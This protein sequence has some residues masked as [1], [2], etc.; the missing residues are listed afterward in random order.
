MLPPVPKEEQFELK[1]LPIE[2]LVDESAAVLHEDGPEG[3]THWFCVK[4][5]LLPEDGGDKYAVFVKRLGDRAPNAR[6][7]YRV[8]LVPEAE[9][10]SE[11]QPSV[12]GDSFLMDIQDATAK[13]ESSPYVRDPSMAAFVE[14]HADEDD[15]CHKQ[16]GVYVRFSELQAFVHERMTKFTG[17]SDLGP[18]G[19]AKEKDVLETHIEQWNQEWA[20][21]ARAGGNTNGCKTRKECSGFHVTYFKMPG[22]LQAKVEDRLRQNWDDFYE[23]YGAGIAGTT[24]A[25]FVAGNRGYRFPDFGGE[26]LQLLFPI[27][28]ELRE[29]EEALADT[30]RRRADVREKFG[31]RPDVDFQHRLWRYGPNFSVKG[32]L[33][34]RDTCPFGIGGSVP[35]ESW[36]L[37]SVYVLYA[38]NMDLSSSGTRLKDRFGI[39]H[40]MPCLPGTANIMRSG[41]NDPLS[42]WHAGPVLKKVNASLPAYRVMLQSKMV[43][44]KAA[45]A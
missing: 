40:D 9:G 45:H 30:V 27:S 28:S 21:P 7:R 13:T 42:P 39:T 3:G 5:R 37:T 6:S 17:E 15:F 1:R 35:R 20:R 16:D 41:E 23:T 29:Y 18:E 10:E 43:L 34:H 14:K 22:G 11:G 25:H 8:S 24:G 26:K 32:G 4:I 19:R 36:Q 2:F 31:D 12:D 33:W 44:R 38:D